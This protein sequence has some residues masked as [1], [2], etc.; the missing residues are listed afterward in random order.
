MRL[1]SL[2]R[3]RWRPRSVFSV[4][5]SVVGRSALFRDTASLHI[6]LFRPSARIAIPKFQKVDGAIHGAR[7]VQQ[8]APHGA[9]TL[10]RGSTE[11]PMN[12]WRGIPARRQFQGYSNDFRILSD[13]TT[14]ISIIVRLQPMTALAMDT[15]AQDFRILLQLPHPPRRLHRTAASGFVGSE[16]FAS[17]VSSLVV[18]PERSVKALGGISQ[19]ERGEAGTCL[20]DLLIDPSTVGLIGSIDFHW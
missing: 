15:F 3:L 2:R 8:E 19:E 9:G 10:A 6:A 11:T 14:E 17:A 13:S 5:A 16:P 12:R 4:V 20:A 18:I 1:L 7:G